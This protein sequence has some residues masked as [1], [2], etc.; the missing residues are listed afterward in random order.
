[1]LREQ[2]LH[3]ALQAATEAVERGQG[4]VL[5]ALFNAIEARHGDSQFLGVCHLGL[6]AAHPADISGKSVG[7]SFH[8]WNRSLP[9][10]ELP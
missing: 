7:E 10:F 8:K 2:I 9:L 4:D 1:M 3:I 6:I 5:R